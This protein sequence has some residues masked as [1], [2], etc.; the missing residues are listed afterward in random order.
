MNIIK[1]WP[2]KRSNG[3]GTRIRCLAECSCG[4]VSEY[5]K[6]NVERG[7]TTRC[8]SCAKE[9]R[10]KNRTKHGCSIS[11]KKTNKEG[12]QN[13]SIWQ[14]M[15]R[16]CYLETAKSYKDYGGRGIKV[17]DRWLESFDNFISDMGMRPTPKHEIDRIDTN[18]DYCPENCR[19]ATKKENARNK[20]NTVKLTIDGVTKP[21]VQ[22]AEESGTSSSNIKNRIRNLGWSEKE[23]V[24]GKKKKRMYNT[25]KGKFNT[26]E[27][28]SSMFD[29]GLTAI[30][31]RFKSKNFPE[32]FIE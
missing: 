20:R 2:V 3:H 15:K 31:R 9:S 19:W 5:D 23:A 11:M 7:N 26:L 24:F 32:W 8:K 27:E 17:C 13:Y 14:A 4:N 21:L 6:G 29:V 1:T 28:A 18:G 10:R 25:P 30:S 12:Y 22:W 16:R